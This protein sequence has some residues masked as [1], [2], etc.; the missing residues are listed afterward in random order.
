MYKPFLHIILCLLPFALRAQQNLVPNASFEDTTHCP[1]FYGD[2]STEHWYSVT[3]A[4]TPDLYHV[5]AVQ[6]DPTLMVPE[7]P[8]NYNG[9]QWPRTGNAYVGIVHNVNVGTEGG[10]Y[11]QCDLIEPLEGGSRYLVEFF[12]SRADNSDRAPNFIGAFLS[13]DTVFSTAFGILPYQPQVTNANDQLLT[14]AVNWQRVADT[15]IAAGGEKHLTIGVFGNNTGWALADGSLQQTAVV[16]ID[17][18]SIIEYNEYAVIPNVF[19]PNGDGKNDHL[20][21]TISGFSN[22]QIAIYDRWGRPVFSAQGVQF[23]WD[24]KLNGHHLNDGVYYVV[25]SMIDKNGH[26]TIQKGFVHL[27]R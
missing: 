8:E 22:G 24:G 21:I 13:E 26:L 14:E 25:V 17:D 23:E 27:L 16:F 20:F 6:V 4:S 18:V 12:V 15:I 9:W 10:E 19:T 5:C 11:I 1:W 3:A 2:F 7:V